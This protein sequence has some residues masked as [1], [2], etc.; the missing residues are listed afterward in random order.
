VRLRRQL[1][2]KAFKGS[3]FIELDSAESAAK[4]V[5]EPLEYQGTPLV[6]LLKKE[7]LRIKKEK[8]DADKKA[9]GGDDKPKAYVVV[10]VARGEFE[11]SL[12][13]SLSTSHLIRFVCVC[14]SVVGSRSRRRP[15]TSLPLRYVM[16]TDSNT[17][18][19]VLPRPLSICFQEAVKYEPGCLL[20]V[21]SI[22][23]G[24]SREDLKVDVQPT[25][26]HHFLD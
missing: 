23:A 17:H 1:A 9:K 3:A 8:Y 2:N 20:S 26:P 11:L 24:A 21:K 15:K 13:L 22:P 19:I 12:T 6:Q 5:A 14:L 10:I 25:K 4:A 18:C 7:Y 16:F